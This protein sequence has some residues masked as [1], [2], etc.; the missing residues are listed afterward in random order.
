[1]EYPVRSW[2]SS[3]GGGRGVADVGMAVRDKNRSATGSAEAVAASEAGMAPAGE[4]FLAGPGF[5]ADLLEATR[6]VGV[7]LDRAG[8]MVACSRS[9]A[10]LLEEPPEAVLNRPLWE[11]IREPAQARELQEL[12]GRVGLEGLLPAPSTRGICPTA[13][14]A[15]CPSCDARCTPPTAA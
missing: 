4:A 2:A 9:F 13:G 15:S 6:S 1:M 5:L 11:I 14:G 3:E 10:D 12:I 7:V 8:C